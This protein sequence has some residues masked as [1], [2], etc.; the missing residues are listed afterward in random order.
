M[1]ISSQTTSGVSLGSLP[2]RNYSVLGASK[3]YSI[4]YFGFDSADTLHQ[5]IDKYNNFVVE[6]DQKK[7]YTLQ[8]TQA[9]YQA[10]PTLVDHQHSQ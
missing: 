9:I 7:E 3:E 4:A 1:S 6:V 8:V 10:I 5:F 2:V